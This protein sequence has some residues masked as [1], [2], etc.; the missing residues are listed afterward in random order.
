MRFVE[1]HNAA[2]P[3]AVDGDNHVIKIGGSA[4]GKPLQLTVAELRSQF[5]PIDTSPS[6]G[7]PATA[8]HISTRL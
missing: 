4:A 2:I 8:A 6:T 3:T 7:A 5:N 1:Y